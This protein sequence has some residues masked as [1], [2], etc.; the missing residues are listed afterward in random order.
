MAQAGRTARTKVRRTTAPKPNQAAALWRLMR[1]DKPVGTLLLLWPTLWALWLAAEGLP[2]PRILT[3]FVLGVIVMRA[4]GCVINDYADRKVD[5]HVARTK[6]RP[7]VSGAVTPGAALLTF[8]VLVL[9]ALLLVLMTNALTLLLSVAGLALAS[10]Y[11]YMKRHTY[12]PQVVLGAAFAWS[13]PMAFAASRDA[14]DN[15]IWLVYTAVV[16]WTVA[17]DTFYA[18]VD[19]PDDARIGVKSTALL[20][21]EKDLFIIGALQVM[22]LLALVLAGQHFKLGLYY[23]LSLVAAG[24][25]F[26]WQQWLARKRD[27]KGCF[28]AFLNNQWVG[29]LVFAG[30]VADYALRS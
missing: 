29:A 12:L 27:P 8:A 4:A 18:M 24:A 5:G 21:G 15:G 17:Y 3:I 1:F 23:Q 13:I 11:P 16:L 19:R 9:I 22:C 30:L 6:Q 25:L 20:F 2:S 26:L 10:I 7:L 28:Q 14:L